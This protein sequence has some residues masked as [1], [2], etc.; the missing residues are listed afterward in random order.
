MHRFNYRFHAQKNAQLVD[1]PHA[2]VESLVSIGKRLP[3]VYSRVIHQNVDL[4]ETI[5]RAADD[6]SPAFRAGDVMLREVALATEF[7]CDSPPWGNGHVS[8][9]DFGPVLYK[10]TCRCGTLAIGRPGNDRHFSAEHAHRLGMP[11][12]RIYNLS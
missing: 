11:A 5:N 7:V 9:N 8:H 3:V 12:I 10:Q 1:A 2:L 6:A 4:A